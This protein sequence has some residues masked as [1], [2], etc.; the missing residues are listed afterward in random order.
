M[1]LLRG[2]ESDMGYTE[3]IFEPFIF[4]VTRQP[5]AQQQLVLPPNVKCNPFPSFLLARAF[6]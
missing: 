5:L 1:F 4:D 3:D 6:V 2:K